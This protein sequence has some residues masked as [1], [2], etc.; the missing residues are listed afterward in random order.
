ARSSWVAPSARCGQS[1][2]SALRGCIYPAPVVSEAQPCLKLGQRSEA[3]V[4]TEKFE[5]PLPRMRRIAGVMKQFS[6]G[7]V[8]PGCTAKFTADTE[9][10]LLGEIAAH[11]KHGHGI[12]DLTPELVS[13][14]RN[15]IR[16]ADAG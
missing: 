8:V 15:E 4:G 16:S 10:D 1:R 3:Y 5:L 7:D 6:C 11:A 14:V 13:A 12:T 2:L 9:Q